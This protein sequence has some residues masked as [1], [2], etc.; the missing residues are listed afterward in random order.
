MSRD[1]VRWTRSEN[2]SEDSQ[3]PWGECSTKPRSVW[4]GPPRSTGWCV[5]RERLASRPSCVNTS[6][7]CIGSA[8]LM[9]IPSAPCGLCSQTS[10]TDWAKFG[11]SIA[12]MAM[13]NWVVR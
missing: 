13:R 8:L 10:V 4:T 5:M 7:R 2:G 11:S 3:R 6:D 1:V 9:T 12:G